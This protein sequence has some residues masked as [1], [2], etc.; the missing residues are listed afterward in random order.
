MI[1]FNPKQM[2]RMMK[3]MGIELEEIEAEEV[4]IKTKN[5]ELIFRNPSVSKISAKGIET[6][7]ISGNYEIV[8]RVT[9]NEEDVKLVMEQAGVDEERA[10]KALKEAKG[11]IAEALIKLQEE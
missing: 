1:P 6:F 11:D 4:I 10:R 5:E 8:E 2:K 7:Q 9:I 3:Q